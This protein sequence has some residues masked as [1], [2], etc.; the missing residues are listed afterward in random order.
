MT[1]AGPKQFQ[2]ET[3]KIKRSSPSSAYSSTRSEVHAALTLVQLWIWL[4][5]VLVFC[6][7][8]NSLTAPSLRLNFLFRGEPSLPLIHLLVLV[9]RLCSDWLQ[10]SVQQ[11]TRLH[12]EPADIAALSRSRPHRV[13]R[14]G[15]AFKH[16]VQRGGSGVFAG[17]TRPSPGYAW[18]ICTQTPHSRLFDT[19]LH[20]DKQAKT[21]CVC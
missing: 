1:L 14:D 11:A 21:C 9:I 19:V 4:V 12:D 6:T 17:A 7:S 3:K 2:S 18:P 8:D 20:L 5:K 16:T 15:G 10:L 13:L